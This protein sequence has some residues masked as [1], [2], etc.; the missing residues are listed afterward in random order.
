MPSYKKAEGSGVCCEKKKNFNLRVPASG[1]W[2]STAAFLTFPHPS[3]Y[4]SALWS[5]LEKFPHWNIWLEK[6]ICSQINHF[7]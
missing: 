5:K 3:T 4:P 7:N 1:V 2:G 6:I